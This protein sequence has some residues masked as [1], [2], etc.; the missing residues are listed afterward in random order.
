MNQM[1]TLSNS[2][3]LYLQQQQQYWHPRSLALPSPVVPLPGQHD[4]EEFRARQNRIMQ[5]DL[6]RENAKLDRALAEVR[7]LELLNAIEGRR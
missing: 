2:T 4:G 5:A 3:D 7:H 6:D 1:Q